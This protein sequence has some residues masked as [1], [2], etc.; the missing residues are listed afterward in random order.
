MHRSRE[1]GGRPGKEA[2][3]DTAAHEPL[4]EG[5]ERSVLQVDVPEPATERSDE[6]LGRLAGENRMSYVDAGGERG[7][8]WRGPSRVARASQGLIQLVLDANVISAGTL[9]ATGQGHSG[10]TPATTTGAPSSPAR[11]KYS[12]ETSELVDVEATCA[13]RGR[14]EAALENGRAGASGACTA[15]PSQFRRGRAEDGGLAERILERRV[16]VGR[17]ADGEPP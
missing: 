14:F 9:S 16:A 6:A 4:A 1:T 5:R 12:R 7:G 8:G 2:R 17:R 3:P 10:A 15:W 11:W 13:D